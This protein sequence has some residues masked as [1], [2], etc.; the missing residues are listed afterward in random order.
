MKNVFL[1]FLLCIIPSALLGGCGVIHWSEL[2][3]IREPEGVEVQ[4]VTSNFSIRVHKIGGTCRQGWS[5]M[6]PPGNDATWVVD[7]K[8]LDNRRW[9]YITIVVSAYRHGVYVGEARRRYN[10]P[11]N[12]AYVDDNYWPVHDGDIRFRSADHDC[13]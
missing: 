5:P 8:N 10:V 1:A 3:V 2:A 4:N 6:I 7:M 12:S 11:P 9:V 13:P